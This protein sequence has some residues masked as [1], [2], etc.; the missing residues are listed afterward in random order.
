MTVIIR[1]TGQR[2]RVVRVEA[3]G[4]L[5]VVYHNKWGRQIAVT[6]SPNDIEKE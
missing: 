6:L 1:A 2:A 3:S 4:N 5:T